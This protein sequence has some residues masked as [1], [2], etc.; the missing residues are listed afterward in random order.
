[1]SI[2]SLATLRLL[3][4]TPSNSCVSAATIFQIYNLYGVEN[5]A[6]FIRVG[7]DAE[8]EV[9]DYFEDMRPTSNM[10]LYV[11][12]SMITETTLLWKQN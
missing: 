11:V 1:M 4:S 7:R 10:D 5:R 6:A 3:T 12:T 2:S 8:K 9:K